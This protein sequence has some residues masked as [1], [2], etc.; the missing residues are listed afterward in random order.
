[1]PDIVILALQGGG[2]PVANEVARSLKA[3]ADILVV[4]KLK[5][6]DTE[7]VFG[8]VTSGGVRVLNEDM[9]R[10]FKIDNST[11]QTVLNKET[12]Q[13]AAKE[14]HFRGNRTFPEVTAKIVILVDDGITTGSSMRVAIEALR[15]LKV[16]AIVLAVPV[17][18]PN[19]YTAFKHLADEIVCLKVPDD[20]KAVHDYYVEFTPVTD[21]E[22]QRLLE[23]A[24]ERL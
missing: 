20:F 17:A 15:Q 6:P 4:R 3:P 12:T 24:A 19:V 18:P 21:E 2:V 5:L 7:T 1:M 22:I 14:K 13:L 11:L 8:A 10:K 9:I 16:K 23:W